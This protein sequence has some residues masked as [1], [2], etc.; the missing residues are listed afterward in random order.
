MHPKTIAKTIVQCALPALSLAALMAFAPTSPRPVAPTAAPAVPTRALFVFRRDDSAPNQLTR[1]RVNAARRASAPISPFVFGNFIEHLGG[2]VYPGLWANVILNPNLERIEDG[3]TRPPHWELTGTAEWTTDGGAFSPRSIQLKAAGD[4]L[5]QTIWLPAHRTNSFRGT[6]FVRG[7]G[8][9]VVSILGADARAGQTLAETSATVTGEAWTKRKFEFFIPPGTLKKGEASRFSVALANGNVAVDQ[10]ELFPD[11]A[12]NGVDPDVIR[13]AKAWNIPILRYPGGNF[14]SGYH[15]RDGVGPR[16]QRPTRRNPAWGGVEPNSFGTDEFLDFAKRIGTT[17]QFTVNAGNGTPEEAAAWVKYV[18]AKS[19]RVKVWEIGNELYGG[20]QIGHTDPD[21]NAQRFVAFRDA[22]L[23]A[24]P[25]IQIIATGKG[26]EYR[27]DGLGRNEN[28]NAALLTAAR[29]GRP[30]DWLS[31]HPLVPLPDGLRPFSYAEQYESAMSH[32]QFV[33][34]TLLPAVIQTIEKAQGPNATT[35]VAP[36]EWGIIVGGDRWWEGPNHDV[37]A[38][39]VFNAL[40]LNAFLRHSDWVTLA[41]MTAFMHGGGIKKPGGV[42]IVDPQYYT[43]KLY[44]DAAPR[45]PVETEWSGP[46]RDVPARGPLPAVS[47]VPD[48]D[49][50]SALSAD[51]RKLTVFAVNRHQTAARPLRLDVAGFS[52]KNIAAV[53]LSAADPQA[54]NTLETPDAVRPRPFPTPAWPA[55]TAAGWQATLPPHSL[56]VVTL[57]R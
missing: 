21:G 56:V 20:W 33:D 31:L 26:D 11:D 19:L 44:A 3:D 4:A 9:I 8:K 17:P 2:V 22:M 50:F 51:S 12:V 10:I 30:P 35:R 36:T 49:V 57:R 18:N 15:W 24:D 46:A 40:T 38:G 27:P 41:N 29:G 14:V 25:R 55:R 1:V 37:L 6:L 23:A 32:P 47:N 28:W 54:R 34:E 42:V 7:N 5:I 39:A 53:I 43:Q 52:S 13:R 45:I 48:V 16:E